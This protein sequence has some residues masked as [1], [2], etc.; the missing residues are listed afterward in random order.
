[1]AIGKISIIFVLG[2]IYNTTHRGW[3]SS[4][5][6]NSYFIECLRETLLLNIIIPIG[7]GKGM[8]IGSTFITI[9]FP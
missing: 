2:S 8:I 4:N 1:M 6:E 3:E 9:L 7:I 5:Y